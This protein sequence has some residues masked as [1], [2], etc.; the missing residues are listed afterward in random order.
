MQ[1]S[2]LTPRGTIGVRDEGQEIDS[3]LCS[4]HR[5]ATALHDDVE[6]TRRSASARASHI[7]DFSQF[8]AR[9]NRIASLRHLHTEL[10]KLTA[11]V[12]QHGQAADALHQEE[13][14]SM[15]EYIDSTS[16]V[17]SADTRRTC[18]AKAAEPRRPPPDPANLGVPWKDEALTAR[19]LGRAVRGGRPG[20]PARAPEPSRSVWD[21]PPR[22]P[23]NSGGAVNVS[24]LP[25][26]DPR[27]VEL[28]R[29]KIVLDDRVSLDAV[30]IP[31]ALKDPR[32][33]LAAVSTP[34]L[35]YIPAWDHFAVRC[36][37]VVFHGNVGKIYPTD[38]GRAQRAPERVKE[39]RH[40]GQC[41]SLKGGKGASCAYY[42]DPEECPGSRDVRNYIADSWVYAPVTTRYSARYGSR[43]IGSRDSLRGDLQEI[44]ASD[45]RRH[46]AQTAHDILC[47]I[48]L[49]KY[50]LGA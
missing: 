39:C 33:I 40:R 11:I 7:V 1:N 35:Y 47:S 32:E 24:T 30:I 17:V 23:P 50:V 34:E 49:A 25:P 20:P 10:Q 18:A 4:L 19:I 37:A 45:A 48:I 44:S 15:Q 3:L 27:A 46:V 2:T 22:T 13:I 29:R 26:A 38:T 9:A 21:T 8:E 12:A 36:G 16:R 14:A 43:R 42:H 6:A 31:G 41:P 28:S 5:V